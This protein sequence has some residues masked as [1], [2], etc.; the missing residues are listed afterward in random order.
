MR[1]RKSHKLDGV[2]YDIRGPVSREAARL[3]EEG[4]RIVKLHTGNPAPFGLGT[5][6]EIVHDI[7]VN[8][9]HSQGYLDD[10]KGLFPA[11]KAVMQSCQERGIEGVEIND[12]YIGNGVSELILMALQAL[13]NRGDEI[14]IPS[15]DYPLWTAAAKLGGGKPVHYL[16]DEQSDWQPDLEDIESKISDRTKGI[17]IISPNNPTG[18]VYEREVVE[19]L[20]DLARKHDLIVFSDEIYD[21][22]LYD[23]A[24]HVSP[25]SLAPDVLCL[26]FNGLSK[27]YRCAG[28]RVGWMVVSGPRHDARDYI[29]GLDMLAGTR[30]CSNVPAQFGVQ[31]ALGGYQSINDL[32]KPGGRLYEQREASWSLI[33]QIPGITCVRPRG[34]LYLFPRIDPG[35][36]PISDD[37]KMVLDLLIQEHVLVVQGTGFNWSVPDH[38]RIVFLPRVDELREACGKLHRF[39]STYRQ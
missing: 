1:Y 9:P 31:T 33:S 11:R 32:V 27:A 16:C 7:I 26:T 2:L 8:F 3:E 4:Y 21:K 18:A 29:E 17:V 35:K 22:I 15:P 5:P 6:D 37:R 13:L 19:K 38:F 24:Q 36:I 39:F 25:A 10:A 20:V 23:D 30:L 12:V 34:A 14:L 28:F